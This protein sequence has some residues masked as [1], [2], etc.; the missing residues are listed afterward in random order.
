M[1]RQRLAN[2]QPT[3]GGACLLHHHG[4]NSPVPLF[5]DCLNPEERSSKFFRNVSVHLAID[6]T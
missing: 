5:M 2:V 4:R 1:T 6:K 3:L